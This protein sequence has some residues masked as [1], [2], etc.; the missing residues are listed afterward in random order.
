[1]KEIETHEPVVQYGPERSDGNLN[2]DVAF[3]LPDVFAIVPLMDQEVFTQIAQ[4][5]F[6]PQPRCKFVPTHWLSNSTSRLP[7]GPQP[8][9]PR[10]P[11]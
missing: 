4:G 8:A 2:D 9:I 11:D 10:D 7:P 3:A 1:M 6:C 5:C